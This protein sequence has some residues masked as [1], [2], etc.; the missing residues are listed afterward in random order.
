MKKV[1]FMSLA[2]ALISANMVIANDGY[3]A[4]TFRPTGGHK[5]RTNPVGQWFDDQMNQNYVQKK[6][7]NV[8]NSNAPS[9]KNGFGYSQNKTNSVNKPQPK[10][11]PVRPVVKSTGGWSS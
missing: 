1:I 5:V 2:I 4:D 6:K 8:N 9:Y 11:A 7:T 3:Y 10:P